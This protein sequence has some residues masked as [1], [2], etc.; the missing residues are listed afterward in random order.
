MNIER[1][2][3]DSNLFGYEVG[4]ISIESDDVIINDILSAN[5]DFKLIYV[6]SDLP[7]DKKE[8]GTCHEKIIYSK[9]V[10]VGKTKEVSNNITL[11]E[12]SGRLTDKLLNLTY[13][14]GAHSRFRLDKRFYNNEYEELYKKWIENSL[15][16]KIADSVKVAKDDSSK[17]LGF[18]TV[19]FKTNDSEIGLIA[20][21]ENARG[22]GIGTLLLDSANELSSN[23][24]C[25]KIFVSTQKNNI[26]ACKFYEK[27]GF[28]EFETKY[29]YHW[30]VN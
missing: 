11:E 24:D 14:S 3:W 10:E 7:I 2:D 23:N 18:I 27:N 28:K 26:S 20:V 19:K 1:L 15:D 21:D 25:N 30:W 17:I 4:K 9:H 5:N 8:F 13:Q 16:G 12:Y 29:I 22:L 6:E